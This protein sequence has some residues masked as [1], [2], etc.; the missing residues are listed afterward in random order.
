MR[1]TACLIFFAVMTITPVAAQPRG[2]S[3][4]DS[5]PDAFINRMMA[6]DANH[7]GKLTRA[8]IA[9]DRLLELFDRADTNHDGIVTRAE[10]KALYIAESSR[11][12]DNRGPG[13]GRGGPPPH[14]DHG[15]RGR[16]GPPPMREQPGQVLS[17]SIQRM[18]NLTPDQRAGLAE[19]QRDVDTRLD[20]LL[21]ADQKAQLKRLEDR[22]PYR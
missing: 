5:S 17:E 20:R 2:P 12:D 13:P 3:R 9:D 18:I 8:E 21:T 10:L 19:I 14:D 16:G 6:F 7:D 4:Y 1:N 11:F 22:G 15:D